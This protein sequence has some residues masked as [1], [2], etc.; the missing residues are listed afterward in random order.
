MR[1]TA[2]SLTR[3]C[4]RHHLDNRAIL[5]IFVLSTGYDAPFP[6]LLRA[7]VQGRSVAGRLAGRARIVPIRTRQTSRTTDERKAA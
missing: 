7:Y 6:M 4:A 2:E 5:M 3:F 1:Y